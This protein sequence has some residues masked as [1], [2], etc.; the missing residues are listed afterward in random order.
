MARMKRGAA[1]RGWLFACVQILV[2]ACLVDFAG[3]QVLYTVEV[4]RASQLYAVTGVALS[5]D[6]G[7]VY[8]I[9]HDIYYGGFPGSISTYARDAVTGALTHVETLVDGQGGIDGLLG[10]RDI[11]ASPDGRH[12]YTSALYDDAVDIFSRDAGTGQLTLTQI[13]TAT[14]PLLAGLSYGPALALSPGGEHLY[15]VVQPDA[16][17]VLSR[18]S[19]SGALTVL[20]AHRNGVAGVD[21]LQFANDVIVSPDGA[22]VY[23]RGTDNGSFS[24]ENHLAVFARDPMTGTLTF[25]SAA[26]EPSPP[27]QG[28]GS[29]AFSPDG[30]NAYVDNRV[31]ARNPTSGALTLIEEHPV[32]VDGVHYRNVS[33]AVSPDGLHFYATGDPL[34]QLLNPGVVDFTRHGDGTLEYDQQEYFYTTLPAA[35][36]AVS[37]DSQFVYAGVYD[38]IDF[39]GGIAVLQRRSLCPPSPSMTCRNPGRARLAVRNDTIDKRDR[40]TFKWL[41]GEDTLFSSLGNPTLDIPS[42]DYSTPVVSYAACVYDAGG[43][44]A[45]PHAPGGESCVKNHSCWALSGPASAHTGVRYGDSYYRNPDGMQRLSARIGTGGTARLTLQAA[46]T[47]LRSL[48]TAALTPPVTAQVFNSLGECWGATFSGSEVTANGTTPA[49]PLNF[50]ARH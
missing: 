16:L 36:L 14:S 34:L 24:Q 38:F 42:L 2:A 47:R 12:V 41:A 28:P 46:G 32:G 49:V 27:C 40:V 45:Q 13:E 37:A 20:E 25:A 10:V 15:A 43:L 18:D 4:E 26:H 9:A 17:A 11:V 31:F 33:L 19:V 7:Q 50:S 35:R 3:A 5:P 39:L 8:A 48:P 23:V 29:I 22:H 1:G 44:V 30:L 21:G 6:G